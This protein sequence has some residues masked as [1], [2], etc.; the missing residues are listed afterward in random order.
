MK[1]VPIVWQTY[2]QLSLIK[3]RAARTTVF[4]ENFANAVD[5]FNISASPDQCCAQF[6]NLASK[7][8]IARPPDQWSGQFPNLVSKPKIVRPSAMLWPE[9]A[10]VGPIPQ[11]L[12]A[13][14]NWLTKS[15][16]WNHKKKIGGK[17]PGLGST[18]DDCAH[19]IPIARTKRK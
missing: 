11:I 1:I 9:N 7:P 12:S 8:K 17:N 3:A 6:P 5:H 16:D 13:N 4:E 18:T 15:A 10:Y 19:K 14:P 2:G